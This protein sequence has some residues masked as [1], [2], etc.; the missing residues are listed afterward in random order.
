[1]VRK[2]QNCSENEKSR[3]PF[4]EGQ[5]DGEKRFEGR[6]TSHR[7]ATGK[8][9]KTKFEHECSI[10]HVLFNSWSS[11]EADHGC[12]VGEFY[13]CQYYAEQVL[14][15]SLPIPSIC[16]LAQID[17]EKDYEAYTCEKSK[18]SCDCYWL[19]T[20]GDDYRNCD[21][22][23]KWFWTNKTNSISTGREVHASVNEN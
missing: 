18:E 3:C 1:M 9:E 15:L 13:S 11:Y 12:L 16:P 21:T 8:F 2:G 4:L 5:C 6:D 19:D 22:F 23:S 10:S 17:S 14:K 20:D 7:D